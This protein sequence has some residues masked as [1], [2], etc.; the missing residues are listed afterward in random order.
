MADLSERAL[1]R[2]KQVQVLY[3]KC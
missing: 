1:L 3:T 2:L